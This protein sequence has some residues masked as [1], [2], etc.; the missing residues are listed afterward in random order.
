MVSEKITVKYFAENE[1]CKDP[2]QASEDAAGYDLFAAETLTLF[3]EKNGCISYFQK[4]FMER[5]FHGLVFSR[6]TL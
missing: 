5:F 3:L 6:N 4:V 2:Y 1:F